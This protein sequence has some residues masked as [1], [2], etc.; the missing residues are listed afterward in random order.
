MFPKKNCLQEHS[1]KFKSWFR[2]DTSWSWAPSRPWICQSC[3]RKG[4]NILRPV[5]RIEYWFKVFP[6]IFVTHGVKCYLCVINQKTINFKRP[7]IL[8]KY[9]PWGVQ[10]SDYYNSE[11]MA[12]FKKPN[13]KTKKKKIRKKMLKVGGIF[14]NFHK[15]IS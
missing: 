8:T 12:A 2:S 7:M 13:S 14:D 5:I 1:L 9:N 4:F 15:L 10:A 3:D 11:E 6:L